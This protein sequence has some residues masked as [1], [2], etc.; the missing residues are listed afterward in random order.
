MSNLPLATIQAIT[1]ARSY[2]IERKTKS[3]IAEDMAISRFRVARLIDDAIERG[4]VK[5]VIE[6]QQVIDVDLSQKIKKRFSL[7]EAVVLAGPDLPS[8]SL[9][10]QLGKLGA[11]VVEEIL[12]PGMR[13]GIASGR[14]LSAVAD[15]LTRLPT[16]DVIQAA[17]AQ[18]GMEFSHNSIELVHRIAAIGGGKAYPIYVPMWVDNPETAQNLLQEPSIASVHKMYDSL[19][20]LLTGI[21]SWSPAESCMCHTFPDEWKKEVFAAGVC[22]DIC[23]TIID[24]NG[25]AIPSPLDRVGLSMVADQV[26]KVKQVVA[27]AGGLEKREAIAAT[28][29]GKWITTLVTDAGV[30][31]YLL[32]EMPS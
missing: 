2:F 24:A 22:A 21:G 25:V 19:D 23:T 10:E 15:A 3:Q 1:V 28:L 16:L 11:S 8:D 5:F 30:A 4:L 7:D 18:P 26:R 27:I 17:G 29:K 32:S 9:V 31:R 14:V 13:V 12:K 6:D 20:V